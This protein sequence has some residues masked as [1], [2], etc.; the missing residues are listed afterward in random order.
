MIKIEV[1]TTI[2]KID[3]IE[4]K[5]A[6]KN[7]E[8]KIHVNLLDFSSELKKSFREYKQK[9]EGSRDSLERFTNP[10]SNY[11]LINNEEYLNILNLRDSILYNRS[12]DNQIYL[13]YILQTLRVKNLKELCKEFQIRGYSKLS[14]QKIIS[15]LCDNLS[16][17]EILTFLKERE[18]GLISSEIAKALLT[19]H[20]KSEEKIVKIKIVNPDLNEVEIFFETFRWAGS[21]FISITDDNITDPERDCICRIGSEGGFCSHFWIGFI[22]SLKNGF[23]SLSNWKLTVLPRNFKDIIKDLKIG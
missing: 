7:N 5:T 19:I 10:T 15:Y 13:K 22:Y 3:N 18:L 20:K 11:F 6:L 4:I 9:R 2:G 21:S 8:K 12:I 23:F 14:K 1:L 17:E 16:Q